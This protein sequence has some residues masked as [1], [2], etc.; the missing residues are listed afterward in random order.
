MNKAFTFGALMALTAATTYSINAVVTR[1][2]K[3]IHFSII[4]FYYALTSATVTG[5][6]VMFQKGDGA[7]QYAN[8]TVWGEI[9]IVCLCNMVMQNMVTIMNQQANPATVALLYYIQI[10]YS[11][12]VDIFVFHTNFQLRELIGVM[13]CFSASITVAVQMVLSDKKKQN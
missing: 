13:I 5:I 4:Q 1:K 6:M 10:F 11:F 8:W 9:G 7:F 12:F 3:D 2:I